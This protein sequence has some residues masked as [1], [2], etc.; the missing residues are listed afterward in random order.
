MRRGPGNAASTFKGCRPA[1]R[2][3]GFTRRH[4]HNIVHVKPKDSSFSAFVACIFGA[5]PTQGQ[6]RYFEKNYIDVF[7]PER[8]VLTGESLAKLYRRRYTSALKI[9][10]TKLDVRYNDYCEPDLFVLDAYESRDLI[11]FWNLRAIRRNLLAIPIQWIQDLS[12][13]CKDFIIRNHRPLPGNPHG[14]MIQPTV[15]FSRSIP[16]GQIEKIHE[17]YLKV[18][19]PG[20]NCI[21]NRYPSFSQELCSN[22]VDG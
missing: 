1:L 3:G 18:D 13:F 2:G 6:L 12:S 14:V 9:G 22:V 20:A 5:F 4:K 16:E 21:Q 19:K 11:D 17:Q 8:I 7:D 15:M 10:E